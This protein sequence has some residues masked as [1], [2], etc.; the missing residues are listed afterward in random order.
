MLFRSDCLKNEVELINDET[1]DLS[2]F[3]NLINQIHSFADRMKNGGKGQSKPLEN[4][5]IFEDDES[6]ETLTIKVVYEET[7]LMSSVRAMIL[8]KNLGNIAE[9][10]KTFP[11]D[12]DDDNAGEEISKNGLILKLIT[13]DIDEVLSVIKNGINV[14]DAYVLGYVCIQIAL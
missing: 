1:V 11:L 3:S 4:Q 10:R 14:L 13:D 9:V 6:E 8:I 5:V 12:L 7:C 2:D